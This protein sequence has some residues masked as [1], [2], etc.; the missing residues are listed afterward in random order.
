MVETELGQLHQAT[1]PLDGPSAELPPCGVVG[2]VPP[3]PKLDY[4]GLGHE[5][6]EWRRQV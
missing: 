6:F 2:A 5:D 4:S 3:G 1:R